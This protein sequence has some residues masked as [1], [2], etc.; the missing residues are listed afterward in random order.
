MTQSAKKI[1]N[2]E[3]HSYQAETNQVLKL[4][5]HSLYS[6]KEI[7]LRELISNASDACDKLRF[8]SLQNPSLV[9]DDTQFKITITLNKENQTLTIEDNGIGM[10]RDEVVSNIGTIARSGTK[11][12]LEQLSG[13][14]KKDSY[15]IGQFGVGF[16]SSFIVAKH[17]ELVTL[18]AGE[19]SGQAVWWRSEGTGSYEIASQEK[20]TRGTSI[21][22]YL[23]DDEIFFL[24]DY[25]LQSVVEK[26]SDHILF[27]VY[28]KTKNEK[29]E[30][31]ERQ[32]N[33]AT[34]LWTRSKSS[35]TKEEY[36]EF[37][38]TLSHD[39]ETPLGWIHSKIEGNLE[40]NVLYYIPKNPPYDLFTTEKNTGVRLY[41]KRVFIMDESDK[42][43]P[44]YLRFIK[45]VIDSSDLP[46]N[47]SRE[48]LQENLI[49]QNI[50][51]TSIKKILD[52]FEDWASNDKETYA[53]LWK[54]YG[55]V[56][57]E[58]LVE[59][60]SNKE[61]LASLIRFSSTFDNNEEQA[62][63]LDDYIL[64]QKKGQDK[65]YYLVADSFHGACYS[66]LLEVF[67]QKGV[68]VLLLSDKIDHWVTAQLTEY[69]GKSLVSISKGDI[70]LSAIDSGLDDKTTETKNDES[71]P[72]PFIEK[73][74]NSL[75]DCVESV[76]AS[77]RLTTSPSCLVT[78]END[79]DPALKRLMAGMG[80]TA[81]QGKPI[82]EL[83]PNHPVVSYITTIEDE[84]ALK[85]WSQFLFDQATIAEGGQPEKPVEY[86]NNLNKMIEE[87]L[88]KA[89]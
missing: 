43:L 7:F 28:L 74:K 44:R 89:S 69:K 6:N 8:A 55:K 27:P 42:L 41:V 87:L 17:V 14:Q 78:S 71:L 59:D 11:E 37:Y 60:F 47:V 10:T 84:S 2:I 76:V 49:I 75:K 22:L 73:I 56:L 50:R 86:V 9:Q 4:V 63:S 61:R 83:N 80:Q 70:D 57:K 46:L 77:K 35:V 23:K 29:G 54:N 31:E 36:Q 18:K 68:E 65:I 5:I 15:L 33:K 25:K 79:F 12:F 3:T 88:K 82:L 34:A 30:Y 38:K 58:G 40:Y 45:G 52:Q 19:N 67:R 32:I 72:A 51:Q 26:F 21:T 13:D 85:S 81:P 62:I 20:A 66:P 1:E 16:Y 64:R 24:E 53:Q 48:L 39:Y